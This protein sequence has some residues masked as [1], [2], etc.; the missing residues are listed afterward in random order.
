MIRQNLHDVRRELK[1]RP[2]L[3]PKWLIISMIVIGLLAVALMDLYFEYNRLLVLT[4]GAGFGVWG[5]YFF[6]HAI[7]GYGA[8]LLPSPFRI[9]LLVI[10]EKA[11]NSDR[12]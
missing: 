10:P 1:N 7:R 11:T 5:T 3:S 8:R 12:F 9:P 6:I 4:S 2:L